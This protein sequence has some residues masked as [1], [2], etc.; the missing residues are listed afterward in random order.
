MLHAAGYFFDRMMDQTQAFP[1]ACVFLVFAKRYNKLCIKDVW[2]NIGKNSGT[3]GNFHTFRVH[4][5]K[6]E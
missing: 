2:K 3:K 5:L 6:N 1:T 4:G